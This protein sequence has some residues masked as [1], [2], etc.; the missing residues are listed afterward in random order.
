MPD[1]AKNKSVFRDKSATA[2]GRFV[3][4]A[5]IHVNTTTTVVRT[6]V[7]RLLSTPAM[8]IFARIAVAAANAAERSAQMSQFMAK[9]VRR[10][11]RKATHSLR[12]GLHTSTIL[13]HFLTFMLTTSIAL[14]LG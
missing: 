8:P 14:P 12:F 2:E 9:T 10:V 4:N 6:A 13:G 11:V 1:S 7:A 3:A 5:S